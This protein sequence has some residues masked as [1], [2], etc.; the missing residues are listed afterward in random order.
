MALNISERFVAQCSPVIGVINDTCG[1]ITRANIA[2]LTPSQLN[3][4]FTPGGLFADLDAWFL[5]QIEMKACGVKRNAFYD[6]I[7]ANADR[8]MF[9]AAVNGIKAVKSPSLLHPFIFGRQM[10]VVNRDYW[11]VFNG[12]ATGG[13]TINTPASP[14]ATMSAGPLTTVA[15]GTRVIRV[16]NRHNIPMDPNW[17]RQ[18]EVIHIFNKAGNGVTLHGAWR[19]VSSAVDTS[20][21][22]VDVLLASENA[23]SSAQF[24]AAPTTGIVLVGVNNVND[25]EKWCQN[26]PNIDPRK[27]VPF[28]WQTMRNA[29]C[30]DSEYMVVY[31]RLFDSNPAFREFGDLPLAE[32]NAQDEMEAQHRFVVAF[33]FQK[34]I[35]ANQTLANWESLE[36]INTIAGSVLDTGMSGKLIARRA[37]FI[38]VKEQL[39]VCDRVVDLQNNILNLNEFLEWNYQMM[40]ARKSGNRSVTDIDWYTNSLMRALFQTAAFQYYKDQYLNMLMLTAEVGKTNSLGMVYDSYQFKRPGGVRINIISDEFFDDLFAEFE[41]AG[42]SSAGNLML[43]LDIG[44]PPNG[45]I[46]WAQIASNRKAYTTAEID[47]LAKFDQ[48]YR[49]VMNALTIDQTLTS[50]A[51]TVVVECP[52]Y[53]AWIEGIQM[54][55]PTN[56]AMTGPNYTNLY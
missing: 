50:E 39:R 18:R 12:V 36:A 25:F 9:R 47:Q 2:H 38:G 46:Y 52:L 17:F 40:R 20:L 19:V 13:Y 10:T 4:I 48:T 56:A 55:Q 14:K 37:N 15:G 28:W 3:S 45:S 34:A 32:R 22:Y 11:R 29:R 53:S 23:G 8:E 5:H 21:T 31:K 16:E 24:D 27:R 6:W 1:S 35:S 41:A 42:L 44:K 7:M 54:A 33:L 51:G 49:C 26:L 30:V 43:A